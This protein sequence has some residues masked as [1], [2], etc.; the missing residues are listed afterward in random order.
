MVVLG[1]GITH[2]ATSSLCHHAASGRTS[3]YESNVIFSGR[4]VVIDKLLGFKYFDIFPSDSYLP[5]T[6]LERD[7]AQ[8]G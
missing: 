4:V 3:V 7:E 6:D 2:S 5:L 8:D 1:I